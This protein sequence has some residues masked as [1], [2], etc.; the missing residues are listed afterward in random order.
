MVVA[1]VAL[2]LALSWGGTRYPWISPQV[3]SLLAATVV[4]TMLFAWRLNHAPEPFLPLP[5][6]ADPVVRTA[7]LASAC[8]VG[9]TLAL[10]LSLP[11]YLQVVH[12]LSVVVSG[13]AL[14]PLVVMTTPGLI[15]SGRAL[16][17]AEHYKR[18]PIAALCLAIAAIAVVALWPTAPLWL[19]LLAL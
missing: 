9:A 17:Y 14:I 8:A 16:G 3:G 11:R 7:T 4:F 12:K 15:M 13:L 2:L 19:V 6:L 10:T 1:A 18:L 5:I